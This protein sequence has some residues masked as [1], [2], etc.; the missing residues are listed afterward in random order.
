MCA[1]CVRRGGQFRARHWYE[2]AWGEERAKVCEVLEKY[3]PKALLPARVYPCEQ[4]HKS[5]IGL[6]PRKHAKSQHL[7]A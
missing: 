5:I 3:P 1:Q 4:I 6:L 7:V 2:S